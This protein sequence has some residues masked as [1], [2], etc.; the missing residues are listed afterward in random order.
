MFWEQPLTQRRAERR[1]RVTF[2]HLQPHIFISEDAPRRCR[3]NQRGLSSGSR[4]EAPL[5]DSLLSAPCRVAA[6]QKMLAA[7]IQ[8]TGRFSWSHR[9]RLLW[10]QHPR[11]SERR[12]VSKAGDLWTQTEDSRTG[13]SGVVISAAGATGGPPG[14][15]GWSWRLAPWQQHQRSAAL[16]WAATL[17]RETRT[18]V[19]LNGRQ[20]WRR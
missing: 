9:Q 17:G 4:T 20:S 6:P 2:D 15:R 18:K 16:G 19:T 8:A 12:V 11:R 14:P 1:R 10:Q 13:R 3:G 5:F 7:G